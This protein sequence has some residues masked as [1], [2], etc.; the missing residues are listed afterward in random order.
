[1]SHPSP[2][3]LV[4]LEVISNIGVNG[5]CL[6][7]ANRSRDQVP[8]WKMVVR[9]ICCVGAGY[10]GGPTTATIAFKCP[11]IRVTVVD[12]NEE[13]IRQWNSDN[14]PIYEVRINS[15]IGNIIHYLV[16]LFILA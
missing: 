13:K 1:M 15:K 12:M 3:F 16:I 14:L 8:N 10:V 4:D 2:V 7:C 6:V 5:D 11:N 9:D